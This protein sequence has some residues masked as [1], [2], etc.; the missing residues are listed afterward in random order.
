MIRELL[1][2]EVNELT[3]MLHHGEDE[4]F[5]QL[6]S[7]L[8]EKGIDPRAALLAV[9]LEDEVGNEYGVI[10]CGPD[11]VFEYVRSVAAGAPPEFTRWSKLPDLTAA[12]R[13]YP[14]VPVALEMLAQKARTQS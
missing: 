5:T 12:A 10:V 1:H 13:E 11:G 2:Q 6:R 8:R 7:M 3:E 14:Q 9:F 4:Y